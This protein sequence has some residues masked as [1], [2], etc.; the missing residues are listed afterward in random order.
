MDFYAKCYQDRLKNE[1]DAVKMQHESDLKNIENYV[2]REKK[3]R[4]A[5]MKR[6]EDANRKME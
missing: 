1:K 6:F 3:N 5:Y 2:Y 4:E